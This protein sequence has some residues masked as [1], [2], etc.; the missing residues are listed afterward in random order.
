MDRGELHIG[1]VAV[2]HDHSQGCYG[3]RHTRYR[4]VSYIEKMF[5]ELDRQELLEKGTAVPVP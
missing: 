5:A 3:Y 4:E 2:L 1:G